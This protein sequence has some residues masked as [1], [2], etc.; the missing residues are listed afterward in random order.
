MLFIKNRN[1][2]LLKKSFDFRKVLD[3]FV[4]CSFVCFI[5]IDNYIDS[6][7]I[8]FRNDLQKNN[9]FVFLLNKDR[10][11]LNNEFYF[12]SKGPTIVVYSEKKNIH[13]FMDIIKD[14][15]ILYEIL[16]IKNQSFF[17]YSDYVKF[18]EKY[19]NFSYL[20][21]KSD[22][23]NFLT[24]YKTIFFNINNLLNHFFIFL[25]CICYYKFNIFFKVLKFQINK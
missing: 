20:K 7:F 6:N 17:S 4:N 2:F 5:H 11:L 12:I 18:N 1:N 10:F 14:S 16:L 19:N 24:F 15:K 22:L 23:F 9:F 25:L 13:N 3:V 8:K 21:I